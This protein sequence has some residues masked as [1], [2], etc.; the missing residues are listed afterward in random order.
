MQPPMNDEAAGEVL[1]KFHAFTGFTHPLAAA[2]YPELVP[3]LERLNAAARP[4][5]AAGVA[6]GDPW[7]FAVSL[8]DMSAAGRK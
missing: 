8:R 2:R 3:E 6:M 4:M 1:L 7:A 5:L